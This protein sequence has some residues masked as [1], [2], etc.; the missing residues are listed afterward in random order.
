MYTSWASWTLTFFLLILLILIFIIFFYLRD[1]HNDP[2]TRA[3]VTNYYNAA[4]V[5]LIIVGISF[6]ISISIS[7]IINKDKDK[8]EKY[9]AIKTI[10]KSLTKENE[11]LNTE[12]TSCTATNQDLV[13]QSNTF[14]NT[15]KQ[16]QT[17]LTPVA[18]I[19]TPK[20]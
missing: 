15:V 9:D 11:K 8:I 5:A 13:Q 19:K 14:I 12:L 1:I 20:V 18:V 6:F 17:Q 10:N 2:N 4:L 3:H 7:I 16:F